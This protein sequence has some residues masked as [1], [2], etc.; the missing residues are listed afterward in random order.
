MHAAVFTLGTD[1]RNSAWEDE[2]SAVLALRYGGHDPV[3]QRDDDTHTHP[4]ALGKLI[5][6]F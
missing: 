6:G 3:A 1:H 5:D 2:A 4:R